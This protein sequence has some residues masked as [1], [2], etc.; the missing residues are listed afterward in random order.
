MVKSINEIGHVMGLETIAEFVE[1][2]SI[3]DTLENIQ[4]DYVQ[5]YY[6]SKPQP[7]SDIA[8]IEKLAHVS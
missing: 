6:I 5:G 7:F 8:L 1:T 3:L 2:K 4:V